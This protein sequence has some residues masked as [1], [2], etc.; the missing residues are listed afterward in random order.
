[1]PFG[2]VEAGKLALFC[3]PH[4]GGGAGFFRFL[5]QTSNLPAGAAPVQYPGHENRRA[6]QFAQT[7]HD[8]VTKLAR[9]LDPFLNGPFAFLGH[10]MGAIAAFEL[11]RL[12][13]RQGRPL[14]ALLIASAARAPQFRRGHIPPPD[15]SREELIK[16]VRELGGLP[17]DIIASDDSVQILLPALDADT[18]LYRRYIYSEDE[19]LPVSILAL[20]GAADPNI[21]PHHLQG[22]REQTTAAF[23]TRQFAGAHFYLREN[24]DQFLSTIS[25]ALSPLT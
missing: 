16:Q 4:A 17:P 18:S 22:W 11:T 25:A 20:G 24:E 12:L 14:P 7:M 1:L 15:P 6:E 13:R 8:L 9:D 10:S 5:R 3:F 2:G 19:P 21:E 23:E